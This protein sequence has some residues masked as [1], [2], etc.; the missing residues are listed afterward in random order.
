MRIP[1]L[2]HTALKVV[3][4]LT[5][6]QVPSKAPTP[7]SSL[8]YPQ[9]PNLPTATS[10]APNFAGVALTTTPGVHPGSWSI[11]KLVHNSTSIL[12]PFILPGQA[13]PIGDDLFYVLIED[14]TVSSHATAVT[15]G[16]CW[17]SSWVSPKA[18][19]SYGHPH[20][21]IFP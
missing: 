5:G 1:V 20:P 14:R 11:S 6:Q 9:H 13:N 21:Y 4:S 10:Q 7:P 16:V 12:P 18:D 19:H 3:K 8:L 17:K 2:P 15:T